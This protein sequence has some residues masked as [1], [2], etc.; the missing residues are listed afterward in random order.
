M[1]TIPKTHLRIWRTDAN[2][3]LGNRDRNNTSINKII[4]MNTMARTTEPG[5]GNAL[6]KICINHEMIPMNTWRRNPQTKQART[7]RNYNMDQ[8]R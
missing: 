3:Q 1:K 5:N 6:Q 2:G 4:G 7:A 8:P